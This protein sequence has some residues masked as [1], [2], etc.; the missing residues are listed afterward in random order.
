MS[1]NSEDIVFLPALTDSDIYFTTS[2]KA[3]SGIVSYEPVLHKEHVHYAGWLWK[4][5]GTGPQQTWRRQWFYLLDDR[6]CYTYIYTPS[7]S[8]VVRYLPLDRIP[9]RPL[10]R[11]YGPRIGVSK[12]RSSQ[13]LRRP[14]GSVFAVHCGRRTHFMATESAALATAWVKKI[15]EVWVHAVKHA[16]RELQG[17]AAWSMLNVRDLSLETSALRQ[18]ID[19]LLCIADH[20][21]TQWA[22]KTQGPASFSDEVAYEVQ[23]VTGNV[24]DGGSDLSVYLE[25]CDN[26]GASSGIFRLDAM[27]SQP[28]PFQQATVSYCQVTCRRLAQVQKLIIQCDASSPGWFIEE[29][30]VKRFKDGTWTHF[31]CNDWLTEADGP[32]ELEREGDCATACTA[33]RHADELST[34]EYMTDV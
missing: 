22:T 29:I 3:S 6:L 19:K 14:Q 16:E 30:W 8:Q 1:Q 21:K 27:E 10:P 15:T 18:S 26:V 9:V 34:N 13:V 7:P 25:L 24:Q 32:L 17:S 4:A 12:V 23:V 33:V 20:E 5:Y 2:E 11:H 31:P 28:K